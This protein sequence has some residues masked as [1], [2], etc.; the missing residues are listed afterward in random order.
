MLL[1]ERNAPNL[2]KLDIAWSA[3]SDQSVLA[4]RCRAE[5][6]AELAREQSVMSYDIRNR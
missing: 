4:T 2:G 1:F 5:L 3:S 6:Q